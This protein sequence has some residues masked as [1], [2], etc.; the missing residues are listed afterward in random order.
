MTMEFNVFNIAKQ[1]HDE[2]EGI[3]DMNLIEELLDY[4]FPSNFNDDS[5]QTCLIHFSLNF[6]IDRLVDEINALLDS[7][8]SIDINKW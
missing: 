2:D 1:P 7:S 5:L 8:L 4:N 3:V 6:N